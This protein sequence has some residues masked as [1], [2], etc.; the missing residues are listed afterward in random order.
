MASEFVESSSLVVKA[1]TALH[2][3]A[4]KA[5]RV[6]TELKAELSK[7]LNAEVVTNHE[8]FHVEGELPWIGQTEHDKCYE[9]EYQKQILEISK[10]PNEFFANKLDGMVAIDLPI[11]MKCLGAILESTK[12]DARDEKAKKNTSVAVSI[13][14][15]RILKRLASAIEVGRTFKSLQELALY[16]KADKDHCQVGDWSSLVSG[17]ATVRKLSLWEKDAKEYHSMRA[18]R[19]QTKLSVLF[20][21][22]FLSEEKGASLKELGQSARSKLLNEIHGAPPQSFVARLAESLASMKTVQ[23]MAELW[24]EV[25][26]EL[27][28]YWSEG[29]PIPFIPLDADPDLSC[30]LL[31]QQLQVI[32]CCIARRKRHSASLKS[33]E[34][35]ENAGAFSTSALPLS[36]IGTC[37]LS[38]KQKDGEFVMRLG[39]DH[40]AAELRML[41]TGEP[42]YSPVT[43]EGPVLTEDLIK[44]N[45]ELVLRTGS[46]GAG[47][48][49]LFSDMQAF[50]ASNPGCILEDFVRWYSPLDWREHSGSGLL[51]K[52]DSEAERS[53]RGC[54]SARMQ[55]EGNLWQ[56]LWFSARPV[57]ALKQAPLFDEELAGESTLD[58][59]EAIEP[60]N[61]FEQLFITALGVGFSVAETAPY[62]KVDPLA[63]C[64]RECGDYVLSTCGHGMSIET[65]EHLCEVYQLMVAAV[66]A[67]PE[68]LQVKASTQVKS[69]SSNSCEHI[70]DPEPIGLADVEISSN[71]KSLSHN[72]QSHNVKV[73]S[74]VNVVIR[75]L[76]AKASIFD[77]KSKST[78]HV[79][80]KSS[81][82]DGDWTLV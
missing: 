43:Q 69:T 74:R 30:C 75:F 12:K 7:P 65:L 57:P 27:R 38:A 13:P 56:E 21:A 17:F 10:R 9:G 63:R 79:D 16:A 81:T 49:H 80:H 67:S 33:L 42:I 37:G 23:K 72:Q 68:T 51:D 77:R 41:E 15:S 32:N 52:K 3:A 2:N 34:M 44:E 70:D 55:C 58:A 8:E 35:L 45:E 47:C 4:A 40:I 5:E 6:L 31:H 26:N 18:R 1:R 61:F 73:D 19:Y 50:K 25:L 54:L 53:V 46:L 36:R 11:E 29:L 82:V 66:N 39:A 78:S 71:M 24:L 22:D 20:D 48:S 76:E 60:S 28:R 14:P 62:A 59:L 64:L